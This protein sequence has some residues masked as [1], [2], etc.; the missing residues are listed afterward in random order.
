MQALSL[1]NKISCDNNPILLTV[2]LLTLFE[3]KLMAAIKS[4]EDLILSVRYI[5]ALADGL[6]LLTKELLYL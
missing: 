3:R 6:K 5:T 2:A 4:A 1:S